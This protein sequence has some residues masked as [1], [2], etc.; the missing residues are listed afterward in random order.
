MVRAFA[1]AVCLL[2]A[3]PPAAAQIPPFADPPP[4]PTGPS[5]DLLTELASVLG[6]AHALRAAC[7]GEGDQTW[8]NYMVDLL[9]YEAPGGARR[10][11]LTSA[12]NR[13]Y[14]SQRAQIS[15]CD[16]AARALEAQVAAR[17]RQLSDAVAES[18]LN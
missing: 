6:Q 12:F 13:G 18:Y 7:A 8:R 15:G 11:A 17:G 14:R 5:I 2:A 9:E 1:F 16:G 10:S 3:A 4:A